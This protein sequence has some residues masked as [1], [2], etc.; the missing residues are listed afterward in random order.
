MYSFDG[1]WDVVVLTLPLADPFSDETCTVTGAN[2]K[3]VLTIETVTSTLP[4]DSLTVYSTISNA[5]PIPVG[6]QARFKTLINMHI[7][8]GTIL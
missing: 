8:T 3:F 6:I 7:V 5:I 1:K 4:V 2:I